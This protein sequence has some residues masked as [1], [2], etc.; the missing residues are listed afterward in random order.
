VA[1]ELL[2]AGH[3]VNVLTGG[4]DVH[5]ALVDLRESEIDG[6]QS[7]DRLHEIGITV[8]R[9]AVPFDTRPPMVTS[10]L[11]VGAGALATRG[12]QVEDFAEVGQIM[13][14]ALT[15]AFDDRRADLAERV[16]AI[17]E[18]YPLYEHL[19]AQPVA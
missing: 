14:T 12:L 11:R 3:G 13:A 10:G 4:T 17:A 7:E 18:R 5:L 9:N 1:A 8:N 15:P 19:A 6:Q 16:A 2:E